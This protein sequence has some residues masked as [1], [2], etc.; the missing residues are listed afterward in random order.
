MYKENRIIIIYG[1]IAGNLYGGLYDERKEKY[2]PNCIKTELG[3]CVLDVNKLWRSL[4]Y[5]YYVCKECNK[6]IGIE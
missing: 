6:E 1:L 2:Y 3:G 4:P 5:S